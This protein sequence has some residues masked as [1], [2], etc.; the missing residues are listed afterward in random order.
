MRVF[1]QRDQA[2]QCDP[3]FAQHLFRGQHFAERMTEQV[4][5]H[6]CLRVAVPR[7]AEQFGRTGPLH[8]LA[9]YDVPVTSGFRHDFY[10]ASE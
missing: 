8:A 2:E 5:S 7:I 9:R 6:D 3:S 1:R 4:K 10:Y